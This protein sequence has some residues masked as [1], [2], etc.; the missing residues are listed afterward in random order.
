MPDASFPSQGSTSPTK[1][2]RL[3]LPPLSLSQAQQSDVSAPPTCTPAVPS[4]A[5]LD[6][7]YRAPSSLPPEQSGNTDSWLKRLEAVEQAAAAANQKN[8]ELQQRVNES[9]QKNEEMQKQLDGLEDRIFVLENGNA[10]HALKR[11]CQASFATKSTNYI[12]TCLDHLK[13]TG[14]FTVNP[15]TLS[16]IARRAVTKFSTS[17]AQLEE[18]ERRGVQLREVEKGSIQ[19][20]RIIEPS[21][22]AQ[23]ER[24]VLI[25]MATII[26]HAERQWDEAAHTKTT[27][28]FFDKHLRPAIIQS[29]VLD[30]NGIEDLWIQLTTVK[31]PVVGRAEPETAFE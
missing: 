25:N 29:G 10:W 24:R 5:A 28:K 9:D 3:N 23:D 14:A 18:K 12:T 4:P 7:R 27:R 19:F 8:E 11:V 31:L 22:V 20:W 16:E 30:N 17:V 15:N 21:V 26:E 6:G 2:R 13:A 1:R